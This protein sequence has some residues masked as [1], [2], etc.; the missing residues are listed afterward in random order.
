MSDDNSDKMLYAVPATSSVKPILKA[1]RDCTTRF[2]AKDG[3][4]K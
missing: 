3:K 2:L 4:V 1:S